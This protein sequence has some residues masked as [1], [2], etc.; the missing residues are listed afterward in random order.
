MAEN[1]KNE[2]RNAFN[3]AAQDE[4]LNAEELGAVEG[5][6]N[7]GCVINNGNCSE[8]CACSSDQNP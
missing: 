1:I 6:G 5:A 7:S 8:G 2:L 3:E 4:L